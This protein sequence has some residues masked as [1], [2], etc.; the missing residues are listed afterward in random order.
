MV[1]YMSR[2]QVIKY[3]IIFVCLTVCTN[4][5]TAQKPRNGIF[6]FTILWDEFGGKDLGNTCT[7][8]I[9]GDSIIAIHDGKSNL[10]GKKGDILVHGA[11]MKHKSG[12]WIIGSSA[13]DKKANSLNGCDDGPTLIDFKR[14]TIRLC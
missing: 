1:I 14:K 8:M 5:V 10:S 4:I 9:D 3:L 13:K 6:Q 2:I 7:V 11:L 12:K